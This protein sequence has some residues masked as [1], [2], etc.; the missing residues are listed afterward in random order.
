MALH[1]LSTDGH[2]QPKEQKELFFE[3]QLFACGMKGKKDKCQ[4]AK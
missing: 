4:G 2:R 1:L 3:S